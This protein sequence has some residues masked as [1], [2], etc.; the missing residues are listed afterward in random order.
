M[1]RGAEQAAV[2]RL[3]VFMDDYEQDPEAFEVDEGPEEGDG[4][5]RLGTV[6][7]VRFDAEDAD[8]LRALGKQLGVPYT[9]LV[10]RFIKE[11]LAALE[12]APL[13]PTTTVTIQLT[14]TPT[15]E[16]TVLP[17]AS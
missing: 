9:A 4:A 6:V 13:P 10:R 16:V 17:K 3:E 7:S 5:H 8:R 1:E 14:V 2:E 12:G 11:R 15:G